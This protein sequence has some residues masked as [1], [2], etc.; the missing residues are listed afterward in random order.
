MS[1]LTGLPGSNDR[2]VTG[3]EDGLPEQ[4]NCNDNYDDDDDDVEN[5]GG[6]GCQNRIRY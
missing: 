6:L 5:G 1:M 4:T 3:G 2:L